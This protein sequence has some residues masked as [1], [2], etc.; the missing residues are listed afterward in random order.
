MLVQGNPAHF[1][2]G[3]LCFGGAL[4]NPETHYHLLL[5]LPCYLQHKIYDAG[6]KIIE[7]MTAEE[8]L[9]RNIPAQASKVGRL[10]G[11]ACTLVVGM[12]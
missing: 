11:L 5:L 4:R 1:G 12:C 9:M 7:N 10:H 2:R 8:R 3:R 6:Q